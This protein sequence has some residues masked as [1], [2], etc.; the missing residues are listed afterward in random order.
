MAFLRDVSDRFWNYVSPRKTQ[1]RREKPFKVPPLPTHARREKSLA[2]DMTPESR[3]RVWDVTTPSPGASVDGAQLPPSPPQSLERPYTDFEGDTIVDDIVEAINPEDEE[4]WDANEDTIVVDES[5]YVD[6][7]KHIDEEAE[8]ARLEAQ[9]KNLRNAGWTEDSVFLF[10][11]LGMRGREPLMPRSW[12]DDFPAL[13]ADLFTTKLD[14]AYIK[15][16]LDSDRSDF[17]AQKA[18]EELFQL[19]PRARD[20]VLTKAPIRTPAYH[21]RMSIKKYNKWAMKDAGIEPVWRDIS[22][23]EVIIGSTETSSNDLQQKMLLKLGRLADLWS[24]AFAL[25]REVRAGEDDTLPSL[26][27]LYGVIASHTIMAFVSYDPSAETP[28][29]RTVA[30]FDFGQEGYDVWNTF[31]VAI[32]IIHCRNRMME[33]DLLPE[34]Q[35][36]SES[37]PDL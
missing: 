37:D 20:A 12:V 4:N 2:R 19:G 21:I 16:A 3:V 35:P 33:L 34:V 5:R 25:A 13:P 36:Q 14:K 29:L 17:H 27:T 10:Q 6:E 30:I 31:A 18:L 32:F 23:F 1:Q 28:T 26:P 9:G 15:P 24:E 22:L 11:K 8:R 7:Q